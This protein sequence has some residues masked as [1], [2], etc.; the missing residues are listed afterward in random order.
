MKQ[1]LINGQIYITRGQLMVAPKKNVV[2]GAAAI[3]AALIKASKASKALKAEK[4]IK[5][6]KSKDP[7]QYTTKNKPTPKTTYSSQTPTQKAEVEARRAADARDISEK[8]KASSS[9]PYRTPADRQRQRPDRLEGEKTQSKMPKMPDVPKK[10]TLEQMRNARL[11]AAR[12]RIAKE[13]PRDL[14]KA[15]LEGAR[16]VEAARINNAPGVAGRSIPQ[17]KRKLKEVNSNLDDLR[18]SYRAAE[19]NADKAAMKSIK[20]QGE[21]LRS[22]QE[23]LKKKLGD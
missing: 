22:Q 15:Q 18:K 4:A 17:I 3:A 21:K 19:K 7:T 6:P 2:D 8:A 14:A 9:K 10:P 16:K 1:L 11:T 13:G 12:E 5:G 23:V 20:K